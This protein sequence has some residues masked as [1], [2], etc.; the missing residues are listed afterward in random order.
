[1][2]YKDRSDSFPVWTKTSV[3]IY[4]EIHFFMF[5]KYCQKFLLIRNVKFVWEKLKDWGKNRIIHL[6]LKVHFVFSWSDTPQ[7]LQQQFTSY[8]MG[9]IQFDQIQLDQIQFDQF[10]SE[11]Y[12]FIYYV[13]FYLNLSFRSIRKRWSNV[14]HSS[15][16]NKSRFT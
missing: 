12:P 15:V 13:F 16:A 9:Q 1:M 5:S 10:N 11:T 6:M 4:D 2:I 8:S 3:S 7:P 14:W